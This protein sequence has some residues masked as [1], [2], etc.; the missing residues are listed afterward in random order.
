M[1]ENLCI[2]AGKSRAEIEI[3]KSRFI[4]EC[5]YIES[6]KDAKAIIKELRLEH[7]DARHIIYAFIFGPDN[8]QT[9]GM[10]DDGEP[11]GTAGRPVLQVLKGSRVTNILC[12][13]IR[14]FG[15]IKLGTGGL[16]RAYTES[17]QEAVKKLPVKEMIPEI[18]FSI[19]AGYDLYEQIKRCIENYSGSVVS[20]KFEDRVFIEI[21]VP[22]KH[23]EE[24]K[25]SISDLSSGSTVFKVLNPS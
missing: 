2:P 13:V 15:G 10:S 8:S 25:S 24:I 5:F 1:A 4:G 21:I 11:K 6:E 22:E 14:Y 18:R 20:E 7:K 17:A 19:T 16:V 12:T 3:K 23:F 9:M